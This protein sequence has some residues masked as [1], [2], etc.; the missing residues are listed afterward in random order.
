MKQLM[1][2]QEQYQVE[3]ESGEVLQAD[4]VILATP[5]Y[6]AGALVTEFG[7]LVIT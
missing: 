3:L 7:F 1:R 2:Q 5:A 6:V 4:G